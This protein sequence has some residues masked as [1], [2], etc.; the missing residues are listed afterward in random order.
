MT[1]TPVIDPSPLSSSRSMAWPPF[2]QKLASALKK[3][4]EDQVLILVVK[5]SNR[6]VQFA[7]QGSYGMRI[8][9]T[10]NSYLAKPDKLN[11][12]QIATLLGAGWSRPSGSPAE[13]TPENDPDGSPNFFSEFPMPVPFEAVASLSVRTFA[14]I[15]RVPHPGALEYSA[16]DGEGNDIALPELGLRLAKSEPPG[17]SIKSLSQVLLDALTK[18]TGLKHLKFDGDGDIAIPYGSALTF[19]RLIN[20][21]PYVYIYSPILRAVE[22]SPDIFARLN[23]MNARETLMRFLLRNETVYATAAI[24][25]SPFVSE[26]LTQAFMHFCAVSDGVDS[27][28]QAEFGGKIAFSESVQHSMRH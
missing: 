13:S 6:F 2:E 16:F 25:A 4:E 3:L 20:E 15:L 22:E 10:S 9:T 28:L 14:D 8:E 11:G 1:A 7:A 18:V 27:L 17:K 5:H 24:C 12:R 26:H 21:P 19:V 23:D